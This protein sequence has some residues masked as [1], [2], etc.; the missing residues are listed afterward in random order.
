[1]KL[2]INLPGRMERFSAGSGPIAVVDY[3]HTPDALEKALTSLR[4]HCRGS[5]SVVFGCGGER[6]RGKRPQMGAIAERLADR[7]VLTDDNPR[8]EDGDVIIR[9]I[10]AGC[11]RRDILV[12]RDRR[13]AIGHA[14]EQLDAGDV[15]L[16]AG[17][18]HED[19][20]DI[21]GVKHPFN[22]RELV[23]QLLGLTKQR[24]SLCA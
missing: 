20:Q 17:K 3:A 24:E 16:V 10:M 2:L 9:E 15:L 18:G 22:D 4:Q 21:N 14:L 8:S 19:T 6:D 13:S 11:K 12:N 7:V 1:M 23:G 5:L